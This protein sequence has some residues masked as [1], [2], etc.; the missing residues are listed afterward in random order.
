MY[1]QR[2]SEAEGL[3]ELPAQESLVDRRAFKVVQDRRGHRN[4]E[5]WENGKMGGSGKVRIRRS[6]RRGSESNHPSLLIAS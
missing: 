5:V 1:G 6:L 2:D 3:G 4:P